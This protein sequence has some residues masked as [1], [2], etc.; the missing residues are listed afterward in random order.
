M[1]CPTT[2]KL[3]QYVDDLL[4]EMEHI[5]IEEHISS[6]IDCK[7]LVET[8]KTEQQFLKETLQT[9]TLPDDFASLVLDKLEPYEQRSVSRKRKTW[10]RIMV[11]AAGIVLAFG[12][13]A[14]FN[15]SFANWISGLF[16]TDQVDEGLRM[17]ADAGLAQRVDKEATDKGLT[18]KVEDVVADSSRIAL[19]YQ[20]FN[21]TGKLED[22]QVYFGDP[23]N[24][25]TVID[26]YGN[27]LEIASM[28]WT[29]SGDDGYGSIELSMR[30][31]LVQE[32]VTI[33]LMLSELDGIQGNW[34]MEIPIDLNESNK[35]TTVLS[36]KDKQTSVNG[37]EL[38]MKEARFNP[39]T[40][41]IVYESGF[42]KEELEKI[43]NEMKELTKRFGHEKIDRFMHYGTS[44]GYSIEQV[45]GKP[46]AQQNI[47]IEGKGH[48]T[49]EGGGLGGFGQI[50]D[51]LGRYTYTDS[52][53]PSKTEQ[54]LSFVLNGVFK[55]VPSDFSITIKPKE[56]KKKTISFEFEG[57]YFTI[58]KAE[59]TK[60]YSLGKSQG[61]K[62]EQE[63]AFT[64][65]MEG[66]REA[67]ATELGTWILVDNNGEI[68]HTGGGGSILD[69]KDK[70]GRYKTTIEIRVEE[71]DEVPEELTLHLV[72]VTRYTE[73]KNKWKVPLY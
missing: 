72:S 48:P 29:G 17:A 36:L 59:M 7:Q 5:E 61:P 38:I 9:P 1:K 44:I 13:T 22:I 66:G 15:A 26:Q 65:E 73:L 11:A 10:K 32:K 14:T 63:T 16:G 51:Q 25:V 70:H 24:E 47:F 67:T 27:T 30:E 12:L 69:E 49:S 53:I 4:V 35:L 50:M 34:S 57:N 39:S 71:M 64:I 33:Q 23:N 3:S 68:Y 21:S 45:N 54:K 8:F 28:G 55:T 43:E 19:S 62:V 42:T 41:E 2:D 18:F 20:V 37:V 6:C 40:N 52:Y 60:E 58:N 56:L 31:H 46:L